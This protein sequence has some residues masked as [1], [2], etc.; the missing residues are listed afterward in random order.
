MTTPARP[1][2]SPGRILA[3][4]SV[5]LI[6]LNLRTAVGA[7]SPII[8]RIDVDVALD[9]AVLSVIG[10]APPLVFAASGLLGPIVARLLGLER[11]LLGVLVLLVAGHVLR[12]VASDAGVLVTGT[13]VA[14]LGAGIG[15]VLLP[16]LV[17]RYFPD[18]IG[19][20]TAVYVTVMSIGAT[21]PPVV[22]VPL[23][24][25]AGWRSALGLWALTAGIAL[26]PWIAELVAAR[27]RITTATA[28][29]RAADLAAEAPLAASIARSPIAWATALM[30]SVAG[31]GAYASFAWLPSLLVET[32]GVD[33]AQA[34][35]LLGVFAFCGFPSALLVPVLAQRLP[36]VLPLVAAGLVFFLGG[37]LGL[38]LAPTAAPWLWVFFVGMGPLLFPLGLTL[39]NLRT[40]THQGAVALS[41]FVQGVGYVVAAAGPVVVGLLRDATGGWTLPLVLLLASLVLMVPAMIVLRAPRFVEDELDAHAAR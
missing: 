18:R 32:A 26:V 29:Q 34:G 10:A 13:V 17:K 22:A 21:V 11:G 27:R 4:V 9:H 20:V 40:R 28:A 19:T 36:S 1:L 14:L 16:P 15:N 41:G 38:L 8:D 3:L 31:I 33:E 25:T 35:V 30:F 12:T 24:D 5:V 39:I 6:A 23:A 7:I 2:L 37:Y